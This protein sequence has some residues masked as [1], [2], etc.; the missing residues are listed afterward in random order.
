IA[1]TKALGLISLPAFFTPT[2][3]FSALAAG[4]DGL[5]LFPAEGA[6]PAVL[7]AMRA[8]LPS[9]VPVFP[10]GGIE[11]DGLSPWLTAGAAGFGIGSALFKPGRTPAEVGE[12]AARFVAAWR[13]TQAK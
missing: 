3:G 12:R 11:P 7:K 8:V 10:V 2:E 9:Q 13:E 5:K 4:A 6:S 1:Q